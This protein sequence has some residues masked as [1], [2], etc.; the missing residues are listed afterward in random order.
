MSY[1][2]WSLAALSFASGSMDV[3]T[4][5]GIGDVFTSAMTG[6]SALFAIALGRGELLAASRSM[7]ALAGF[8]LGVAAATI[9]HTAFARDDNQEQG[10]L[11]LLG[12][13]LI[14]LLVCA[15]VWN[16]SA[17]PSGGWTLYGIVALSALG[18][19]TQAAAAMKLKTGVPGISTIVF[20]TVLVRIVMVW[21]ETLLHAGRA[22]E[23]LADIR[24][25]HGTFAAYIAGG[26]VLS[27][28]MF[29]KSPL[30]IAVPIA[31]VAVAF[32]CL[33]AARLGT[34][35]SPTAK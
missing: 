5:V 10:L 26:I 22:R 16:L 2:T 33:A 34:D 8:A 20:T 13:E 6:N 4:Y 29:L 17:S 35:A 14:F 27:S 19:G 1:R 31:A 32:G 28:A 23:T 15:T 30:L 12:L 25:H 24:P 21:T 3:L 7:T 18:M 11:A 9:L